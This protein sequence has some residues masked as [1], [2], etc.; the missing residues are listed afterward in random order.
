MQRFICTSLIA[1]VLACGLT[2]PVE[3]KKDDESI[4]VVQRRSY[5]KRGKFEVTP[6]MAASINNKFVGFI[7]PALSL[8]YHVRENFALEVN[9]GY[10]FGYYS[11]LVYEVYDYEDLIPENVDLKQ[12]QWFA[13]FSAQWSPLYGK[14]NVFGILGDFDF[15]LSA[16]LGVAATK[17]PCLS[18]QV[19]CTSL[20]NLGFGLQTPE[21]TSDYLKLAGNFGIGMRLFFADW[22]G[23]RVEIHDISYGDKVESQGETT[24]DIRNNLAAFVG[25]SFLF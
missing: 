18:N 14:F 21:A 2:T 4:Y 16:G 15:Y 25:A 8:A 19:G 22:L 13:A 10:T 17:E 5:S 7:G 20:E 24:S 3:A 12:L 11:G 23:V 6:M 9:G 1:A